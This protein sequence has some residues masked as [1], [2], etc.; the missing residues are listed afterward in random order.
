MWGP[1]RGNTLGWGCEPTPKE[2]PMATTE[3]LRGAAVE[4][5]SRVNTGGVV[6]RVASAVDALAAAATALATGGTYE[7]LVEGE[8]EEELRVPTS[9]GDSQGAQRGADAG[10]LNTAVS[11]PVTPAGLIEAPREGSDGGS[12][13]FTLEAM[14]A[15]A[16]ASESGD[17]TPASG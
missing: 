11:N 6:G 5:A 9:Q 14:V 1:N 13:A 16:E 12:E 2:E 10:T 7:H 8:V 17:R 15:A 4:A 3:E